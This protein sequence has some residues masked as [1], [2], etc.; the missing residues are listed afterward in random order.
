MLA[1]IKSLKMTKMSDMWEI[2][3]MWFCE[4]DTEDPGAALRRENQ[5]L[6]R[7]F[8]DLQAFIAAVQC[9]H[10]HQF[11][12]LEVERVRMMLEDRR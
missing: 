11:M 2:E 10:D 12:K 3:W 1:L 6:R 4:S 5:E 7:A 9:L 8:A